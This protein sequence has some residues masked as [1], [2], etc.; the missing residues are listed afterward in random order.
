[1]ESGDLRVFFSHLAQA[2]KERGEYSK[3]TDIHMLAQG[4]EASLSVEKGFPNRR[5]QILAKVPKCAFV[6]TAKFYLFG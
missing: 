1:M 6:S 3:L 2:P 5:G 4:A